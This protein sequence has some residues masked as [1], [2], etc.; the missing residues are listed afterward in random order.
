MPLLPHA[1]PLPRGAGSVLLRRFRA[2]DLQPFLAYRLDS[3]VSRYQSWSVWSATEAASV[4]E[5]MACIELFQPGRWVQLAV[6][7]ADD[8][9][10]VGDVGLFV[11]QG[12]AHAEIG[13]TIAPTAQGHGYATAAALASLQLL[14]EQT[15][16]PRVVGI[17]DARNTASVRVLERVGMKRIDSRE[18]EFKGETCTEW[19]YARER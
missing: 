1:D 10:L 15:R 3:A 16:I 17:T 9:A 11:A 18:V 5:K 8:N 4:I 12:F 7:T 14:F 13:Y 2:E 19:I 6:A